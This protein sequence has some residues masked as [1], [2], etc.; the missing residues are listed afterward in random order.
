MQNIYEKPVFVIFIHWNSLVR[1]FRRICSSFWQ[2]CWPWM[3]L[4]KFHCCCMY[5]FER[6]QNGLKSKHLNPSLNRIIS[7][8]SV[9]ANVKTY[10]SIHIKIKINFRPDDVPLCIAGLE[11]VFIKSAEIPVEN[12]KKG[13]YF[14]WNSTRH[15]FVQTFST[16]RSKPNI[17]AKTL[18][19]LASA[20]VQNQIWL[21]RH[22]FE[23]GAFSN[24]TTLLSH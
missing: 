21:L 12:D 14:A 1:Q 16:Y 9:S 24:H 11:G 2:Y 22:D 3:N 17:F 13:K 18:W 4:H 6:S 5:K 20:K 10:R 7:L 19:Y 23:S 8:A 15:S